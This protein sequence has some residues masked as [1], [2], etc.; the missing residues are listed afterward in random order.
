MG[1]YRRIVQGRGRDGV[2][3]DAKWSERSK[4][5]RKAEVDRWEALEEIENTHILSTDFVCGTA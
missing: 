1:T 5:F 2:E 3:S 4:K